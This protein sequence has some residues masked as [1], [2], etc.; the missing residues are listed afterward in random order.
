MK[1]VA[2]LNMLG[3]DIQY[4]STIAEQTALAE[5]Q[6]GKKTYIIMTG[7]PNNYDT[8]QDFLNAHPEYEN[9]T[10]WTKC[11]L[12]FTNSLES[13]TGKMKKAREKGITIKLY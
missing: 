12:V 3:K 2:I 1:L 13:N 8:K 7:E 4:Y 9:T 10:S 6:Q 5:Q 11:Q